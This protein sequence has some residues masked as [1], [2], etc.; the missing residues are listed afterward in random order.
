MVALARRSV[1]SLLGISLPTWDALQEERTRHLNEHY[2][3]YIEI[4]QSTRSMKLP[5]EK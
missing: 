1:L 2:R 5:I 4:D 3:A